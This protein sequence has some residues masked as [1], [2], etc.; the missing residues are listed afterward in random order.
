MGATLIAA[1]LILLLLGVSWLNRG[2]PT[3][4]DRLATP[5]A[6]GVTL[7]T[8]SD[9]HTV[10]V[11]PSQPATPVSFGPDG[12]ILRPDPVRARVVDDSG[13]D[14]LVPLAPN[15][16]VDTITGAIVPK[17]TSTTRP[18]TTGT[19]RPATTTTTGGPTTTDPPP[20]PTTTT[21]TEE[22]TTTTTT[23]ETTTTTTTT[24]TT[25]AP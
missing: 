4:E 9:G 17:P 24:D 21:T 3:A 6:D 1:S 7:P 25:P 2:D 8:D 22:P 20:P 15:T 18:G 19:T 10:E 23:T 5:T 12:E 16:T 14:I 13:D 11:P